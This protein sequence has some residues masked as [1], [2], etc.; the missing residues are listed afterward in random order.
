[1]NGSPSVSGAAGAFLG[2]LPG[3]AIRWLSCQRAQGALVPGEGWLS[4]YAGQFRAGWVTRE[5]ALRMSQSLPGCGWRD[6]RL[7]WEVDSWPRATRSETLQAWLAHEH[8][9]GY[10]PAWRNERFEALLPCGS[11]PT[12]ATLGYFCVERSGFRYLGMTSHAVHLNGISDCGDLWAGRR[13]MHK[14][15]DAGL[16]DS[17]VA[18]GVA[19]GEG[20]YAAM[21][22]ELSEEAG[23]LLHEIAGWG[24][25]GSIHAQRPEPEGWHSEVLWVA[26]LVLG[27]DVVPTNRDGEVAEFLSLKPEAA[28]A[29]MRD[30]AFTQDAVLALSL[31]VPKA[32]LA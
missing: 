21:Q 13:A 31:L 7:V 10:L 8:S 30:G 6:G 9:A 18:G 17:F 20:L 23:L 32:M 25:A 26:N 14:A 16:L 27:C 5:R 28:V 22:R 19:S 29:L 11:E 24:V 4:W 1:M 15:T 12:D 2:A 3:G